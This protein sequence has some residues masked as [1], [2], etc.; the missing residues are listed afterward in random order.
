MKIDSF[1]LA[2]WNSALAMLIN[3]NKTE[4]AIAL[5]SEIVKKHPNSSY[6][7]Y[8]LGKAYNVLKKFKKAT[9]SLEKAIVKD[10]ENVEAKKL[11]LKLK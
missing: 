2:N 5:G 8:L 6:T 1:T 7:Y 11:L 4:T 9:L 3:L 10:P